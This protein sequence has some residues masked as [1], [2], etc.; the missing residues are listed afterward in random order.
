MDKKVRTGLL[1]PQRL[2]RV[3][4]LWGLK[5]PVRQRESLPLPRGLLTLTLTVCKVTLRILW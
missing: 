5:F 3:S 1:V 4:A 2:N